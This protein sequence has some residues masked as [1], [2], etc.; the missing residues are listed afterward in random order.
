MILHCKIIGHES[1]DDSDVYVK[2]NVALL[3]KYKIMCG[4]GVTKTLGKFVQVRMANCTSTAKCFLP[5]G[6]TTAKESDL[7]NISVL[8]KELCVDDI[9]LIFQNPCL[10]LRNI[11]SRLYVVKMLTFCICWRD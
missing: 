9:M 7:V 5:M 8:A 11:F 3:G 6:V 10:C 2:R 4:N 1:S